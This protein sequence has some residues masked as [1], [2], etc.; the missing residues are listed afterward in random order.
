MKKV[1]T[2][3]ALGGIL[4]YGG[5]FDSIGNFFSPQ[6]SANQ[7]Q[8]T[9]NEASQTTSNTTNSLL[10]QITSAT[11]LS[12]KQATGTV[13]TLMQY[14]KSNM[15]S[16]EYS[17]V[18]KK[19]PVLNSFGNSA[20]TSMISSLANSVMTTDMVKTSLKT[21][22][23]DPSLVTTIIPIIVSYATNTGGK[24]VGS[25]LSKSLSGLMN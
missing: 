12:P 9:K 18:A 15:T 4:A 13:G 6:K 8:A 5:I 2:A 20:K 22:G 1:V 25:I 11:N 10:N 17:T 3:L 24:E 19:V 7:Y 16:S 14:A 23:V 21:L